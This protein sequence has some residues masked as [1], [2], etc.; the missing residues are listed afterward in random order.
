MRSRLPKVLH[1]VGGLP[2]LEHSLRLALE[3]V[4]G[5]PLVVIPEQGAEPLRE[6]LGERAETVVQPEPRGTGDAL[7]RALGVLPDVQV[8]LALPADMPLLPAAALRSLLQAREGVGAGAAMLTVV[9]ADAGGFGRVE[10]TPAGRFLRVVE[11]A[12]QP[13]DGLPAEVNCGA[14]ALRVGPAREALARLGPDN[15]QG[16]RYLS[17]LPQLIEGEVVTV[18]LGEAELAVQVNDRLQLAEA[19][20]LMRRRTLERLMR[21]GVTVVDPAA[22]WV[23]CEV[24]V[25]EDTTLHPGTVLRGRTRIGAG[26]Q[27]GPFAEMEDVEVGEGCRVGRA[28]L[29]GCKL[30]AGVEVGPFNRVRPQS[31]LGP[32]S[33]LGT[34]TEVVRTTIGESTQVPHLS[35][36]GDAELGADVNVGAGSITANWDGHEKHRTVVEDGARLGSDT[37]LVAPVRVGEG[38]YTGAG[39]VI[40]GDVPAQA[41][42]VARARQRNLPDYARR[43]RRQGQR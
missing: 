33:H 40:T 3:A 20:A 1:P 39:S 24:E 18:D 12:D 7:E 26:C 42:G 23:D 5:T 41:L 4:G 22:T 19:E 32:R 8:V 34:F 9:R 38:A 2:L 17:W 27:I 13:W 15:A 31:T 6:L 14:Y 35:Y 37:I 36:L 25:G 11:E 29:C 10:R 16:E 28:H 30:G 21:S 43:A